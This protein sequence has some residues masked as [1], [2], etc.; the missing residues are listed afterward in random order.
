VTTFVVWLSYVVVVLALYLRP[1]KRIPVPVTG[2]PA[3]VKG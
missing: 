2:S 1:V 3:P